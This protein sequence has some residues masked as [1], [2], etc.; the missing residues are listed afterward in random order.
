MTGKHFAR[1]LLD[2]IRNEVGEKVDSGTINQHLIKL[3]G[4]VKG[5]N[6]K[7]KKLRSKMSK[8]RTKNQPPAPPSTFQSKNAPPLSKKPKKKKK[9][10]RKSRSTSNSPTTG[11]GASSEIKK[12]KGY[13]FV[14]EFEYFENSKLLGEFECFENS[15]IFGR[16]VCFFFLCLQKKSWDEKKKFRL[17]VTYFDQEQQQPWC[18]DDFCEWIS[19]SPQL[20]RETK[21]W[22]LDGQWKILVNGRFFFHLKGN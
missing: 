17:I 11:Y 1:N 6:K 8:S 15:K 10:R 7:K 5:G 3:R 16:F 20:R 14:C 21:T 2:W 19:L 18:F 12:V 22:N 4:Y 13:H 9:R